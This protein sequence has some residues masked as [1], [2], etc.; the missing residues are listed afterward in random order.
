D[1]HATRQVHGELGRLL[2]LVAAEREERHALRSEHRDQV[3]PGVG[4]PQ[5]PG[6]CVQERGG[7][8]DK[9]AFVEVLEKHSRRLDEEL[10]PGGRLLGLDSRREQDCARKQQMGRP[11]CPPPGAFAVAAVFFRR[12][13][14]SS[15][16]S[17]WH[18]TQS[19]PLG[20]ASA[21][22]LYCEACGLWQERHVIVCPV[23]GSLT[24]GPY[25]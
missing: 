22:E 3:V 18:C 24:P 13:L 5:L 19:A 16:V 11:H 10:R 23:R 21:S 8:L 2:D 14:S 25:G 12:S 1:V 7:R 4:N 20:A 9:L 15:G 17:L 6:L